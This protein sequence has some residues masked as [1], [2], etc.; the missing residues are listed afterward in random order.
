MLDIVFI[1][2]WPPCTESDPHFIPT[3]NVL[4]VHFQI[5]IIKNTNI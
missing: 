1:L 5:I 3:N 2:K 4:S